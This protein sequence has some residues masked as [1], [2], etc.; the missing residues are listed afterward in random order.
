MEDT[1]FICSFFFLCFT[2]VYSR[3]RVEVGS[4]IVYGSLFE[5]SLYTLS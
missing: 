3:Y 1:I 5:G 2:M 4:G